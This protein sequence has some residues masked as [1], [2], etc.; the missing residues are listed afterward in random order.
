MT[1]E[2]TRSSRGDIVPG[3]ATY[4]IS[5]PFRIAV[6]VDLALL[7]ILMG[8][9]IF[10]VGS[11]TERTA[12][13]VIFAILL[14]IGIEAFRRSVRVTGEGI[15]LVKLFREKKLNWDDI[16]YLGC[17]AVRKKIYFL[18]TTTKGFH[19]FSNAYER[20]PELVQKVV[21]RLEPDKVEKEVLSYMT[22]PLWNRSDVISAWLAAAVLAG[23]IGLK[24]TFA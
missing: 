2:T 9:S 11:K 14:L 17:V 12:L 22:E 18:L 15:S 16:T 24:F 19:I 7:S 6:A 23:L 21:D 4:R 3:G 5:K 13:A 8:L 10:F 1:E 20:Y